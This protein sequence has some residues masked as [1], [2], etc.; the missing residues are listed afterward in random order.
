[1]RKSRRNKAAGRV[2]FINKKAK[3]T[4]DVIV[5]FAFYLPESVIPDF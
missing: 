5:S 4:N 1:M 2:K 3:L